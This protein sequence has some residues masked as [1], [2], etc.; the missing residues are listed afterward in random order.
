MFAIPVLLFE[1]KV[2]R[3]E[4]YYR[5][6]EHN[7][8]PGS[9]AHF[10]DNVDAGPVLRRTAQARFDAREDKTLSLERIEELVRLEAP[11][12]IRELLFEEKE[13]ALAA[14][15]AFLTSYPESRY[16]PNA[17][18]IQGR[19]MDMRIDTE[20]F[21]RTLVIRHYDDFPA[22]TSE[23]VWAALTSRYPAFPAA[24]V[25]FIRLAELKTRAGQVAEAIELLDRMLGSF[26]TEPAAES[27]PSSPGDW[28]SLLGKQPA[29]TTLGVYLPAVLQEGRKLRELLANNRDPARRD[30][31]LARLLSMDPHH[32]YYPH[33]LRNLLADI[34]RRYP[35]TPLLDNVEL[36][37]ALT[38][39]SQLERLRELQG[40]IERYAQEPTA[41]ALPRARYELGALYRADNLAEK[42]QEVFDQLIRA[43]PASSW[44]QEARRQL[45]VMGGSAR[46]DADAG[47]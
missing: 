20:F 29:G 6:L 28:Q 8:G 42:A 36:L 40:F 10:V 18:Y 17:L 19:A 11:F 30:E 39:T 2:G 24:S 23:P 46:T 35:G 16:N 34:P 7:W 21:R 13:D 22:A 15:D 27:R 32:P 44:A 25:G 47:G 3:D 43:H 37:V 5:L 14:C 31:P 12:S 26:T 41:D 33:N 4:L 38:R 45:A 9:T 1:S